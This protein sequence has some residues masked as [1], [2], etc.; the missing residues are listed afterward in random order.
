MYTYCR[1]G[2]GVWQKPGILVPNILYIVGSDG[3]TQ[4]V[5]GLRAEQAL[6]CEIGKHC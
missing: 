5:D 6:S 4:L 1:V 3:K 2:G